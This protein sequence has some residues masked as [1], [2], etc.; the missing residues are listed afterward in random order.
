MSD[1]YPFIKWVG[2]KTQ[3]MDQ[4]FSKFPKEISNYYEPFI[5]GGS[6]LF[7]LLN[8]IEKKEI[9]V[10]SINIS[11]INKDLIDLYLSIKG[12]CKKLIK[13]LKELKE[14][15]EKA[16]VEKEE[17]VGRKK[18]QVMDTI[19]EAIKAGREHVYYFYRNKFNTLKKSESTKLTSK[20]ALFIFLNKTC[21]RGV[22]RENSDGIFNVPYGNN[23][24]VSMFDENNLIKINELL[25]K[26]DVKFTI[27]NFYDLKDKIKYDKKT[28]VYL[29]P[30][31]YPENETSFTSYTSNDFNKNQHEKLI[32]LCK[33]INTKKSKFLLSN[34]N[35]S[36]IKDSLK[37]FNCGIVDCKR[38][39]N[40]K[41]PGAETKEVLIYNN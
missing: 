17:K 30:P 37:D 25:K 11:D 12:K 28:F 20:S 27:T 7:N 35:T 14:N 34:S 6:V 5:G 16:N 1:I 39:I 4:V 32:E 26:Y 36:F 24:N 33:F 38:Q 9:K 23:K 41:N 21:F 3:L 31:Y 29:D 10:D 13:K 22:Y 15:Y 8:K 2:G 40:S 19:D 18:I